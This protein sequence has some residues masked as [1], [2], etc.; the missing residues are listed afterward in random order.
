MNLSDLMILNEDDNIEMLMDILYVDEDVKINNCQ[1]NIDHEL[2]QVIN[3]SFEDEDNF[4]RI[5]LYKTIVLMY[6]ENCDLKKRN[7]VLVACNDLLKNHVSSF[8][9]TTYFEENDLDYFSK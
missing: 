4:Y 6:Q 9:K 3:T 8:D 7:D 1:D 2:Q 5:E